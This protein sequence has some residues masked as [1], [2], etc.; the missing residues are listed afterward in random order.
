MTMLHIEKSEHC[1]T[2]KKI[3]DQHEY[4]MQYCY[5]CWTKN[6]KFPAFVYIRLSKKP[7]GIE[8]VF[9]DVDNK[10]KR[11]IEETPLNKAALE[12]LEALQEIVFLSDRKTKEWEKAKTAIKRAKGEA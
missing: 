10:A 6:H 9:G 4:D 2:C 12:L 8:L 5:A 7:I 3:Y 1:L 11:Y